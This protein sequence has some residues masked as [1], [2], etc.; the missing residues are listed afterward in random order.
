M[1][2]CHWCGKTW[3]SCDADEAALNEADHRAEMAREEAAYYQAC[4]VHGLIPYSSR[5]LSSDEARERL[6][7]MERSRRDA[8]DDR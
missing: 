2:R 6:E 3:C 5:E 7:E 1:T 8:A 4:M